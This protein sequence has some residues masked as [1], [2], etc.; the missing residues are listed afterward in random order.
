MIINI[1]NY[2]MLKEIIKERRPTISNSS[3]NTYNSILTNLYKRVFGD[4][5]IDITNFND[6]KEILNDLKDLEPNKRKTILS[7]LVVITDNNKYRDQM[8]DDIKEHRVEVAK[9]VKS[10]SQEKNWVSNTELDGVFLEHMV[11]FK[12]LLKKKE[13]T[14]SD[15]QKMQNF[16]IL[17]LLSGKFIPPRRLK[18]YVDFKIHEINP[19]KDNFIL[20]R[21][22]VFNSYKTAKTY[23]KQEVE[24][25]TKLSSILKQ[26]IKVNPT[27]YLLFDS[28]GDQLTNVKLNQRLNKIFGKEVSVNI[29]RHMF[30]SDKYGDI[31]ETKRKL[32]QDFKDMGSSMNQE[33]VYIKKTN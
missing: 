8:L 2:I 1:N 6:D 29:L 7:A 20:G 18:D 9:Q 19:D 3:I 26:W 23:G 4:G 27:D 31:I 22:L 13:H 30:L 12:F 24:I 11:F 21:K 32:K 14:M 28:K 17:C 25:P 10:E 16:I 5:E 15:L 33:E